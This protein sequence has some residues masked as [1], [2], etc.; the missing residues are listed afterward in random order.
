MSYESFEL[1]IKS[2]ALKHVARHW[3]EARG[4]RMM[5]GWSDIRPARIT[6]ELAIIWSYAYDRSIDAFTGRL[7]GIRIERKLG[8][9]FKGTPMEELYPQNEF[10]KLFTCAKRVVYRPE[11]YWT[12]GRVFEHLDYS[13]YGER[14][15]LPLA[16]DG[17]C[18]D[19]IL[20]GTDYRTIPNLPDEVLPES[21]NRFPL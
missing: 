3:H 10:Q 14:I 5:P 21:E 1:A 6:G 4:S 17:V 7:A 13:G 8:K 16:S 18:A 12:E 11:L 9:T 20:G 2:P 15:I 19:G